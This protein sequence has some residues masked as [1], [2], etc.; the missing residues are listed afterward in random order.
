MLAANATALF[1]TLPPLTTSVFLA[2]RWAKLETTAVYDPVAEV[3][4]IAD[5]LSLD[6]ASC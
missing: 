3:Q 5:E 2:T 4:G 6:V 1:T